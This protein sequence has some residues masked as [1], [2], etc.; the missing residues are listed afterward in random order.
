MQF[1]PEN[2]LRI[3]QTVTERTWINNIT[4]KRYRSAPAVASMPAGDDKRSFL[5]EMIFVSL[6][7]DLSNQ[8]GVSITETRN[9]IFRPALE[10]YPALPTFKEIDSVAEH[11]LDAY[12][13]A[14]SVVGS[15]QGVL[16]SAAEYR[17]A[18]KAIRLHL[19][20]SDLF[21]YSALTYNAHQIHLDVN[22]CR[23]HEG[24]PGLV[25]HGP[26]NI[27]LLLRLATR[28]YFSNPS[29]EAVG[30]TADIWPHINSVKYKASSPVCAGQTYFLAY[31]PDGSTRCKDLFLATRHDGRVIMQTTINV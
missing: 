30:S 6:H 11:A 4:I 9:W 2:L 20:P 14:A 7:K 5:N 23:E 25:V 21:R 3:G 13:P 29:L 19:T 12:V 18:K 15:H 17:E 28:R 10:W 24:F 16:P 1:D 22:K 26:L 27:S 8:Y 31:S